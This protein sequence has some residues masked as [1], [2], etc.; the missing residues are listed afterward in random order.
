MANTETYGIVF[1]AVAALVMAIAKV[2][3]KTKN[4]NCGKCFS[5]VIKTGETPR[6]TDSADL[7][8]LVAT[9]INRRLSRDVTV[10]IPPL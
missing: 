1:I 5:C 8:Q 10:D 2:V 4:I 7:P 3:E 9:E 6:P